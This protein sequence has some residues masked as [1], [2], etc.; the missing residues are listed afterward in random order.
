MLST[1]KSSLSEKHWQHKESLSP[2]P[3]RRSR[4]ET[5]TN[6][7]PTC[8]P[9]DD[10]V[11]NATDTLSMITDDESEFD[12]NPSN[13]DFLLRSLATKAGIRIHLDNI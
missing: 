12:V 5:I 7:F 1:I 11:L 8:I 13:K 4:E 2:V 6:I 10:Y 9:V 3:E